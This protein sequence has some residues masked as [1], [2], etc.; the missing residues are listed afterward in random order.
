MASWLLPYFLINFA[1]VTAGIFLGSF[2]QLELK[3]CFSLV[4]IRFSR[5][6]PFCSEQT[7]D[8]W[9]FVSSNLPYDLI[10]IRFVLS[11]LARRVKFAFN[12]GHFLI[13]LPFHSLLATFQ[14]SIS[15]IFNLF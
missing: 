12:I 11:Q 5:C 9:N 2:Y 10:C 8:G 7:Y 4:L 1:Q 14:V 6:F 13:I 15:L 3:L